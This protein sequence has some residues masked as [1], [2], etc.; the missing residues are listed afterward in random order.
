MKIFWR[1]NFEDLKFGCRKHDKKCNQAEFPDVTLSWNK[2]LILI[3]AWWVGIKCLMGPLLGVLTL[4]CQ[5]EI[6]K[7]SMWA[8]EGQLSDELKKVIL[9]S[10]KEVKWFI[11]RRTMSKFGTTRKVACVSEENKCPWRRMRKN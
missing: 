4:E 3:L 6:Q 2:K 8:K 5:L 7:M 9:D 11:Y 1:Q 10:W